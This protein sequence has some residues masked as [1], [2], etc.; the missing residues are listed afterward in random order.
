MGVQLGKEG[1][2]WNI[3]KSVMSNYSVLNSC[4]RRVLQT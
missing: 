1:L 2:C 4:T 3:Y